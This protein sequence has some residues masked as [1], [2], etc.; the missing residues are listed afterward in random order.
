[1]GKQRNARHLLHVSRDRGNKVI[2]LTGT[3]DAFLNGA[4]P[5]EGAFEDLLK[6]TFKDAWSEIISVGQRLIQNHVDV[7]VP[8]IAVVNGPASIHAELALLCDIVI[9]TDDAY[10]QDLPHFPLG[11]VPG[12]GVHILWLE[13]LGPNRG[14][15]FLTGEKKLRWL[16]LW[17]W[18]SSP[19]YTLAND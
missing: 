18:A 11:L 15:S 10:F 6:P 1:M 12:D 16:R 9:C 7:E 2:I 5:L 17:R 4:M 8:M 13:L 14:R 19:K 3:G